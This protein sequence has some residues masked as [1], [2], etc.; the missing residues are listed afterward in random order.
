VPQPSAQSKAEAADKPQEKT[1]APP[2]KGDLKS[3]NTD[4]DNADAQ[5]A[6]ALLEGK[7]ASAERLVIQVG[8]FTDA[9]KVREVRRKLEDAG[10]KTFTQVVDGKDD[11][12]TTRVRVGPFD[13]REEADKVAARI[14]KL[15]LT[16]AVLKI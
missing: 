8:A 2:A 4:K 5:K 15:N 12:P 3:A 6:K 14:R 13:N 9:S 10:L 11:K 1:D 7:A 16:P